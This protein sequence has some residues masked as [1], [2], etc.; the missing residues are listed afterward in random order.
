MNVKVKNLHMT[1]MGIALFVVMALVIK[2]VD[3]EVTVSRKRV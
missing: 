1:A 3:I 2:F